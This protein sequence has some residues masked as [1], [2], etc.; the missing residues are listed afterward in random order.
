M[1]I[2]DVF[3]RKAMT[4]YDRFD[5]GHPLSSLYD[6]ASAADQDPHRQHRQGRSPW[7]CRADRQLLGQQKRFADDLEILF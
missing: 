3:C 5:A 4:G 7:F 2:V 1:H 6:T